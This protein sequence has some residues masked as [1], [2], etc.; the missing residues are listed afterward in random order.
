MGKIK[1]HKASAKRFSLTG[2]GKV[3]INHTNR[4][5]KLGLKTTKRKRGLRKQGYLDESFARNVR[6]MING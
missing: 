1:T 6:K 2:T 4:R 5:H 3:R